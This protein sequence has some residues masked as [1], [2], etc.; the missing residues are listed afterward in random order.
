MVESPDR[1][2]SPVS[3]GRYVRHSTSVVRRAAV[4]A[5]AAFGLWGGLAHA[6]DWGPRTSTYNNSIVVEG[7][8]T[9][10]RL[11]GGSK[12]YA[13][14]KDRKVDGN[15]VYSYT[16]W[17]KLNEMCS[18]FTVGVYTIS[19]CSVSSTQVKHKSS[20]EVGGTNANPSPTTSFTYTQPWCD[21]NGNNCADYGLKAI[22]GACAQM[23]W[24]VPDS[25]TYAYVEYHRP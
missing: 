16:D 6:G 23:G 3:R 7:K 10:T 13:Y 9:L 19:S 20:P 12:S 21:S 15:N 8:G 1:A 4:V 25:C 24:P 14:A 2:S 17:R 11:A 22:A 5:I 18:G